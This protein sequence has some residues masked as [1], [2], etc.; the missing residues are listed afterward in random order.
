M[1]MDIKTSATIG[2]VAMVTAMTTVINGAEEDN[3]EED[4][5]SKR[6]EEKKTAARA[7]CD[8]EREDEG[9]DE[10]IE[11]EAGKDKMRT[12]TKTRACDIEYDSTARHTRTRTRT[13]KANAVTAMGMLAAKTAKTTR[14]S[15]GEDAG[16]EASICSAHALFVEGHQS[17]NAHAC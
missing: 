16:R 12:S 3:E 14:E 8:D 10:Y 2:L 4:D 17:V 11:E 5:A 1:Y 15:L 6:S 7:T 9:T 13:K